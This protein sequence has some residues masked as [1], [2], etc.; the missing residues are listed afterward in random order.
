MF[1]FDLVLYS[2]FSQILFDEKL[3][4]KVKEIRYKGLQQL[5]NILNYYKSRGFDDKL[6]VPIAEKK[7]NMIM[8]CNSKTEMEKIIKPKCPHY[9]GNKFVTDDYNVLEEELIAWS[10][11]SLAGPLNE[12]GFK[13]YLEVFMLVFP[14]EYKKIISKE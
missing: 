12:I 11:T 5:C 4:D 1:L 2:T 7:C 6:L 13:R 10:E 9:D 3:T 14:D 8:S